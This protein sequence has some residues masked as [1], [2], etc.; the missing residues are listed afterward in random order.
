MDR[1]YARRQMVR[2][3]VRAWDV[4]DEE[5]LELLN[6]LQRHEF[7]PDGFADLA[8]ADTQIPLPEGQVMMTPTVEGKLLQAV[9]PQ[10][11]DRVLDVGAGS[12]FLAACLASLADSVLSVDIHAELVKLARRN[13][14]KA[15]IDNVEVVEMDITS[16]LPDGDFDVIA[17]SGSM[18]EFDER[19]V[20]KLRS[21][22]RL[23]VIVGDAPVMEAWLV[24]RAGDGWSSD[25]LFETCIK[26]L[27]NA[28]RKSTFSF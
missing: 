22:G 19:L 24:T 25:V 8:Y 26:P 18:A 4:F 3:Q 15:G 21:D 14:D 10:P 11:D 1:D 28:E 13:L 23:F 5:T 6:N 16:E 12:G 17:V 7:V 2:Q 20:D 9:D 27:V